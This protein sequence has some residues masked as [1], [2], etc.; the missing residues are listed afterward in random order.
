MKTDFK[1][2][3]TEIPLSNKDIIVLVRYAPRCNAHFTYC[4]NSISG[5]YMGLKADSF[6]STIRGL[7]YVCPDFFQISEDYKK[8][9]IKLGF[10]PIQ[11]TEKE[12]SHYK[13]FTTIL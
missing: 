1:K 13:L 9:L 6:I 10:E 12:I 5:T 7:L 3:F 11:P 4:Y 8:E 2:T